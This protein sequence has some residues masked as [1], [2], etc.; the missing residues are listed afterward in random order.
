MDEKLLSRV[1]KRKQEAIKTFRLENMGIAGFISGFIGL[2]LGEFYEITL[3]GAI[4]QVINVIIYAII[5]SVIG[6]VCSKNKK[7]ELQVELEILKKFQQG[8]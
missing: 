7:E 1:I 2:I 3:G 4:F 5:G 8:T 6:F